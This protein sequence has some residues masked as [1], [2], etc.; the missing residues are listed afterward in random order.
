MLAI[1]RGLTPGRRSGDGLAIDVIDRVSAGEDTLDGRVRLVAHRGP[2]ASCVRG[3]RAGTV[4]RKCAQELERFRDAGRLP[5]LGFRW[6]CGSRR[7]PMRRGAT[8]TVFV[9]EITERHRVAHELNNL[10]MGN[11]AVCGSA[12]A[13]ETTAT[14]PC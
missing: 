10:L 3:H 7:R 11:P 4:S 9:A 6:N 13:A 14:N 12:G 2:R 1:E 8:F 5:M